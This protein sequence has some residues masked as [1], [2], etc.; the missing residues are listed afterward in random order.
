MLK[1]RDGEVIDTF[2]QLI[3]PQEPIPPMITRLTGITDAMVEGQPCFESIKDEIREFC[4][5][6]IFVAH[7]ARFD[8]S[9]IRHEFERLGETFSSRVLCSVRL[10][11]MLFKEHTKHNLSSIMER[12]HISVENRHRAMDDARAVWEFF[13]YIVARV[14]PELQDKAIAKQLKRPSL[15]PNLKTP[16]DDI[17]ERPGVYFYRDEHGAPIY[18]GK[19]KDLRSR[20]LSHFTQ[21]LRSDKEMRMAQQVRTIDVTET[22]GELAALLLESYYIKRDLPLY[23][24]RSRRT[25]QLTALKIDTSGDYHR[26]YTE[27]YKSITIEDLPDMLTIF[28]TRKDAHRFLEGIAKDYQLCK[29]LVGV[30]KKHSSSCF[31]YQIKQCRGAC[32]GH[33][34]ALQY[35]LRLKEAIVKHQRLQWPFDGPILINEGDADGHRGEVIIIDHWIVQDAFRYE[36]D[37]RRPLFELDYKFDLDAF[38]ILYGYIHRTK[39]LRMKVLDRN[40]TV[41]THEA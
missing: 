19:A 11:R 31:Y 8:Y 22:V 35:N 27:L 28:K 10:S 29:T 41:S 13:E 37:D 20:V 25:W 6:S 14:D 17:P 30:E 3:D 33:E 18:I 5:G 24:R 23:N 12:C 2:N 4:D 9:F 1:V 36:G 21:T 39:N 34:P 15:P 7:N 38:R 16:L 40:A 26:L 32:D